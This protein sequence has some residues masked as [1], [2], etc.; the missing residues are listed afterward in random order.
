M[1]TLGLVHVMQGLKTS[2]HFRHMIAPLNGLD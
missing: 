2:V 1:N